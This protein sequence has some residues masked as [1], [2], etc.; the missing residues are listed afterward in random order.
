MKHEDGEHDS[1]TPRG[2]GQWD[3]TMRQNLERRTSGVWQKVY[4][5]LRR[6]EGMVSGSNKFTDSKFSNQVNPKDMFIVSECKDV[7]AKHV[8]EFLLA[9][10]YSKKP[11][12]IT[13]TVEKTIFGTLFG[14]T[15]VDWTLVMRNVVKKLLAR[16]GKSKP[17]SIY[18]YVFY[19]YHHA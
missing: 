14:E 19:L 8:L 15:K 5:F 1:R 2:E 10:L 6:R 13:I 4:N 17:T 18:L 11:T 12:R 3:R 9:I 16:V 7:R